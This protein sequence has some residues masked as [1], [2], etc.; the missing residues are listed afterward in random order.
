MDDFLEELERA[1]REWARLHGGEQIR[2]NALWRE[3]ILTWVRKQQALGR[4]VPDLALELAIPVGQLRSWLYAHKRWRPSDD[5]ADKAPLRP[6]QIVAETVRIPDGVPER[7]YAVRL[8]T[9]VVVRDL[10]L[11]EVTEVLRSLV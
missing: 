5:S 1:R 6:L 8:R 11:G 2:W 4:V 7:R 9:G 10:T 3:R